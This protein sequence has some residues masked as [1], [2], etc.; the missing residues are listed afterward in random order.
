MWKRF[1][2][3]E[4]EYC[5]ILIK[6]N[7]NMGRIAWKGTNYCLYKFRA[8]SGRSTKCWNLKHY[9][10]KPT[11]EMRFHIFANC[12]IWGCTAWKGF[13]IRQTI[14]SKMNDI[15]KG[16]DRIKTRNLSESKS[17]ISENGVRILRTHSQNF[18]KNGQ[19]IYAIN[20][21]LLIF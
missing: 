11:S 2:S 7:N 17:S 19:I 6:Y 3:I 15:L 18:C 14:S 13:A 12:E 10:P 4:V 8:A 5:N 1:S 21:R 16:H 20:S 9:M